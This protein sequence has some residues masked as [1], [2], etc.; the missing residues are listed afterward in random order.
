M[1]LEAGADPNTLARNESIQSNALHAAVAAE[2]KPAATRLAL[3]KLLL[4]YRA[5]PNA[6][7]GGGFRPID[8]A[9]QN[10]DDQLERLLI[11]RGAEA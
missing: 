8:A 2:N 10:G 4:D 5:D 7:Q 1:L 9:R 11:A 6:R 3:T